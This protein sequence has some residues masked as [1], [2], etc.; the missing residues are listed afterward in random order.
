MFCP[1]SQIPTQTFCQSLILLKAYQSNRGKLAQ[2]Q[3]NISFRAIQSEVFR[4]N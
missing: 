4:Q 1:L 3:E 2:F